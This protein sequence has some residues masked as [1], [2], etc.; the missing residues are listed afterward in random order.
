MSLWADSPVQAVRLA[1]QA[2]SCTSAWHQELLP[3][4]RMQ[5]LGKHSVSPP[6]VVAAMVCSVEGG[7][8]KWKGDEITKKHKEI[9]N[10]DEERHGLSSRRQYLC[11]SLA[12][13]TRCCGAGKQFSAAHPLHSS[14]VVG[15]GH[16][17]V[18]ARRGSIAFFLDG[19]EHL[20]AHLPSHT[21]NGVPSTSTISNAHPTRPFFHPFLT[22]SEGL[23]SQ[24]FF[25]FSPFSP[26]HAPPKGNSFISCRP[27]VAL[28]LVVTYWPCGFLARCGA[29]TSITGSRVLLQSPFLKFTPCH[30]PCWMRDAN[31]SKT[32]PCATT[33]KDEV[34]NT[35]ALRDKL[36]LKSSPLFVG[37]LS[38]SRD[39]RMDE[40]SFA[41]EGSGGGMLYDTQ[42]VVQVYGHT[43]AAH[44]SPMDVSEWCAL[45]ARV[46]P[47]K[48]DPNLHMSCSDKIW[49]W[50]L[51]DSK[52]LRLA[53]P[54]ED[55]VERS[56]AS[57][58]VVLH[59][60]S[61]DVDSY[62]PPIAAADTMQEEERIIVVGRRALLR[63]SMKLTAMEGEPETEHEKA[64]RTCGGINGGGVLGKRRGALLPHLPLSSLHVGVPSGCSEEEIEL[65][66]QTANASM[67]HVFHSRAWVIHGVEASLANTNERSSSSLSCKAFPGSDNGT[68]EGFQIHVFRLHEL[69]NTES[70]GKPSTSV[71]AEASS[72][73]TTPPSGFPSS[74]S[75][76]T[77]ALGGQPRTVDSSYSR[78]TWLSTRVKECAM[79]PPSLTKEDKQK[80][81]VSFSPPFPRALPT[82]LSLG[83]SKA[84]L[85]GASLE[86]PT[87]KR[88][89]REE[90]DDD[91]AW[92][93]ENAKEKEEEGKSEEG[94]N[95][96]ETTLE[97]RLTFREKN[98]NHNGKT[99]T[100]SQTKDLPSSTSILPASSISSSTPSFCYCCEWKWEQK[101]QEKKKNAQNKDEIEKS[102]EI[103][104]FQSTLPRSSLTLNS[105]RGLPQGVDE[106]ALYAR[107]PELRERLPHVPI[108]PTFADSIESTLPMPAATITT[109]NRDD[110]PCGSFC[111]PLLLS[112]A[113]SSSCLQSSMATAFPLSR[114]WLFFR[115]QELTK[116]AVSIGN[117]DEVMHGHHR[118]RHDAQ[119][120]RCITSA[121]EKHN[122]LECAT[123]TR[124]KIEA[125]QKKKEKPL[126][127]EKYFSTSSTPPT[128]IGRSGGLE[129]PVQPTLPSPPISCPLSW[130]IKPRFG[131]SFGVL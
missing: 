65:L 106:A 129:Y 34:G 62:P 107:Y 2:Q 98:E 112:L 8:E 48:G 126:P 13:G 66:S 75:V 10:I 41:L 92:E 20:L 101:G 121:W 37:P 119:F 128:Q 84:V 35:V 21:R 4:L 22:Y 6:C 47:G 29:P 115:V 49:R 127:E 73:A 93:E 25:S 100:A 70:V 97:L 33:D 72:P 86:K 58:G 69:W 59:H 122:I 32:S 15:D 54:G 90:S 117:T 42:D 61:D 39:Y 53:L 131:D 109:P 68:A 82:L 40:K 130:T 79:P 95:V 55:E 24:R 80:N 26:S 45:A 76:K 23:K 60:G 104:R 46:K 18:L 87:R 111:T 64:R 89:K 16:A 81:I 5:S 96:E 1:L 78:V 110:A 108:T 9:K 50:S 51:P 7:E 124:L 57:C 56:T 91:N 94:I 116:Y 118:L 30:S 99:K 74:F 67:Q 28:H 83:S 123:T 77:I 102:G 38:S 27:S 17:E 103:H 14:V 19:A 11:V 36:N 43:L 114:A 12:S 120:A 3:A 31:A 44:R 113:S 85:E 63:H 105:K 125:N 71:F 88:I 52:Y